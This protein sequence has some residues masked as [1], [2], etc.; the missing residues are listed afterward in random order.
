MARQGPTIS[1]GVGMD[2]TPSR[3]SIL[4]K[5]A[6]AK[7]K[8]GDLDGAISLLREAYAD[9]ATSGTVEKPDTFLRLPMY[10]QQAGRP[11][12]AWA[13]FN[14]MLAGQYPLNMK[15]PAFAP[16]WQSL[17]YDK[18]RLFLQREKK[19][20][21]AV[22]YAVLS[23]LTLC[24]WLSYQVRTEKFP[25]HKEA[26]QQEFQKHA[27]TQGI[28]AAISPAL[29]KAKLEQELPKLT[30]TIHQHLA[31]ID[32]LNPSKAVKDVRHALS[33]GKSDQSMFPKSR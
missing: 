2:T 15:D 21:E 4:L 20:T 9:I 5:E 12:E 17:I 33:L 28:E 27:S 23:F 19:N 31:S 30:Q 18:M 11:D 24:K 16:I 26:R 32:S 7:K 10:L 3:S 13:E 6:T 29:K 14:A 1:F 25:D 22:V 8:S